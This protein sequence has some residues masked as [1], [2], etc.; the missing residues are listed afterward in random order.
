MIEGC[1][2][3]WIEYEKLGRS[4]QRMTFCLEQVSTVEDV[5]LFDDKSIELWNALNVCTFS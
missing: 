4:F 1:I 3:K 2:S 5:C